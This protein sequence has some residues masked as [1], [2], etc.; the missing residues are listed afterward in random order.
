[1]E[2]F[3]DPVFDPDKL[4]ALMRRR[5]IIPHVIISEIPIAPEVLGRWLAKTATPRPANLRALARILQC[6]EQDL[7]EEEK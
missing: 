5:R 6:Q 1:M 2:A 3:I 7:L 4:L